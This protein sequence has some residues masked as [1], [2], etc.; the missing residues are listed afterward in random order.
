MN[1]IVVIGSGVMG[2]GIAAHIANS[3]TAVVMLDIVPVGVKNRNIFTESAVE[4]MLHEE[5]CPF[6]LKANAQLITCGNLEDDLHL[7]ENADW[8]IEAVSEKLGVKQDV[9]RKIEQVRKPG[10]II[11]SNT[12]TIPLHDLVAGMPDSFRRDMVITHFFNPPRSMRLLELVSH[13]DTNPEHIARLTQFIDVRLGKVIVHAKDTPGFIANRIGIFWL[14]TALVK[15]ISMGI[16]VEEADSLMSRPLGIPKTG[17]F[18]LMDLVGIDLIPMMAESML[19]NLPVTDDLHQLYKEPLLMKR[20]ISQ[21]Y[22][23]RKGKGGFYRLRKKSGTSIRQVMDLTSGQYRTQLEPAIESIQSGGIKALVTSNDKGGEYAWVVMSHV[24]AYACTLIPSGAAS[25]IDID[26]AMRMGFNWKYGPFELIDQLGPAWF[27]A[28][29]EEGRRTV[30]PLLEAVGEGNFYQDRHYYVQ[31]EQAHYLPIPFMPDAWQLSDLTSHARPLLSN[32]SARLWD[33]G[34][35]IACFEF[36]SKMNSLDPDILALLQASV[37]VVEQ[38]F[39]GLL[40]GNDSEHFSVGL[41]LHLV[42]EAA[43][44]NDYERISHIIRQGQ[45]TM[46]RLKYAPFP[47]VMAVSGMAL[48]GACEMLLHADAVQA[49]IDSTIGLVESTIGLIPGWGG[50]TAMLLR[51]LHDGDAPDERM[52]AIFCIFERIAFAKKASSAEEA[53]KKHMLNDLSRITMNRKRLLADAK[54][55]CLSLVDNYQPRQK[56][57]L[58]LQGPMI[59]AALGMTI[60]G[61][62]HDGKITAHDEKILCQLANV[63]A[64]GGTEMGQPITEQQLYDLEHAAFMR[65]IALEQTLERIAYTLKTGKPLKN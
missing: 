41:N 56:Q 7:I 14:I 10:S 47:V 60:Y 20:M 43:H 3:G 50:C 27:K 35:G 38:N 28:K 55:L 34:D 15:A 63:L 58:H 44:K 26:T 40:I 13:A 39:K 53:R 54:N 48:G 37:G 12:S 51:T 4:R 8:I 52:N 24:L 36:T 6:S 61:L 31:G 33:I 21:G 16:T 42:L 57:M 59:K 45:E 17:I 1:K 11:S 62:Q 23:G 2:S 32:A 64:G 18:G 30:P 65:L 49:H 46:S 22:I 9:Y 25:I 29:L 19:R 5:H